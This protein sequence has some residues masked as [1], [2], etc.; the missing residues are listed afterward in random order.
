LENYRQARKKGLN[1]PVSKRLEKSYRMGYTELRF[2]QQD[3]A[4]ADL[5]RGG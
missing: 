5:P 3:K 1:I 2:F 4:Y